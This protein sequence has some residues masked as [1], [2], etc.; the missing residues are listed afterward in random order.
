MIWRIRVF[1]VFVFSIV[2]VRI[3][4]TVIFAFVIKVGV[5]AFIFFFLDVRE[6]WAMFL[7]F[8]IYRGKLSR[9]VIF[10]Y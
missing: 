7:V 5:L 1:L 10:F 2:V 4:G 3:F 8:K 9:G 6:C